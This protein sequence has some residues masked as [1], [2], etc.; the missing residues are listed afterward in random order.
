MK[1][2]MH[3][4]IFCVIIA[5]LFLLP[6]GISWKVDVREK[7]H[8]ETSLSSSFALT[9]DERHIISG[10]PYVAQSADDYYCNYACCTIVFR[11]Y[12]INVTLPEVLHHSGLGYSL[13]A[14]PRIVPTLSDDFPYPIGFPHR[15]RC[16][17]G[18]E[19]SLGKEDAYFLA[20]LYGLS[21]E[22]LYPETVIDESKCWEEYWERLKNYIL[23]D[24]PI[25]TNVD[26]TVLPY[27]VELFNLSGKGYHFS[28][29][30]VIVGFDEINGVVYYHD[31]LCAAYTSAEDGMYA[32]ISIDIFRKAV[33]SVHWCIWNGWEEGYTTLAFKKIGEPLSRVRVFELA[34]ERNIRRMK[35]DPS[36]YD[37]QSCTENFCVFGIDALH[38]LEKDFGLIN[39]VIRAPFLI[40]IMKFYPYISLAIQ[41]YEF[42]IMEKH[43]VSQF[44]HEN[45]NLSSI[46]E[47]DSIL[48]DI[49]VNYWK[50]IKSYMA[51]LNE[52][53]NNILEAMLYAIPLVQHI[54]KIIDKII[55]VEVDIVSS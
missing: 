43:N 40:L 50:E 47:H 6:A 52:N 22:Y 31:P 23:M 34:H 20:S 46:C 36:S 24:T 37:A 48:L 2:A 18:Q 4:S 44:L 55:D 16:W 19:T 7:F 42:V 21:C 8:A 15:F 53:L 29:N 39:F 54:A 33:Y 17:C 32:E 25:C 49:E 27:Y 28:H 11:Y 10:V 45:S 13:A 12:G 30:I 9:H 41:S 38:A 5:L 51:E 3:E 35:G 1:K 14:R 26:F